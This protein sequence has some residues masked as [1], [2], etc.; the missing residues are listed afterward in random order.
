M[1]LTISKR[2]E[3]SASARLRRNDLS[4]AEN[5]TYFGANRSG[6]YGTGHNYIAYVIF[7]GPVDQRTG[8]LINVAT[9]KDRVLSLI[10]RRYDH[11]F[12]NAD[13]PPFDQ[14]PPTPENVAAQFLKDVQPLF[15]DGTA[16]PVACHIEVPPGEAATAYLSGRVEND[17]WMEFSAARRT[18]SPFLTDEE[19]RALFGVASSKM[20]HGHNYRVRLT[21]TGALRPEMG[22]IVPDRSARTSLAEFRSLLD[23]KNLNEEVP[24]L[25]KLPITTEYLS[26]FAL[27]RLAMT[28]PVAR[29]R[30]YESEQF[31]AEYSAG[32]RCSIGIV[33]GFNAAHRLHSPL[34]D[35]RHN[36]TVYGRCNNP[37][38]HGHWYKVEVTVSGNLDSR[39]GALDDLGEFGMIVSS[40]LS[41]WE[42]KH[43]DLET[44]D[45]K[46]RPS[47]SE[48]IVQTL[49]PRLDTPLGGRLSRLR[50]WET[51]NNRF[52]LRREEPRS[53]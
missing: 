1:Y 20:G 24:E 33:D 44:G 40:A 41:G 4:S 45:F 11:K 32:G 19:N 28:M 14:I 22:M 43:L 49:W 29:V 8:M 48:N 53:E 21:L 37:A 36:D 3:F 2:F 47:T 46:D 26:K 13:T 51:S 12:L 7:H 18:Y 23:H 16:R 27:E 38:G 5:E 6:S 42:G 30:M 52:T 34:L 39:T 10:E 15:A 50:V 35:E 17:Y 25:S 31:F 9:I